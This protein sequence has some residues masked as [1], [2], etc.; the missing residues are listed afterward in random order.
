MPRTAP[1]PETVIP[2]APASH[3]A[4]IRAS[5]SR[6]GPAA[7]RLSR[8]QPGTVSVPPVT[9]AAARNGP[10][11]DRSGSTVTDPR[12]SRPGRTCQPS[13]RPAAV[14][15]LVWVTSAP[16]AWSMRTVMAMCGAEGTGGPSCRISMPSS[17]RGAASSS[18]EISCEEPDASRVTGPPRTRPCP[19]TVNGAAPRPP[20]SMLAPSWRSAARIGPMGRSLIRSSPSK[21]TCA[22]VK[23]ATAGRNRRTVP[24]LPTSTLTRE[25]AGGCPAVTRH[26]AA[27]PGSAPPSTSVTSLPIARSAAAASRVSRARSGFAI[28]AGRSDSAARTRARLVMDLDAGSRTRPRTGPAA[29]GAAQVPSWSS[30]CIGM[31]VLRSSAGAGSAWHRGSRERLAAGILAMKCQSRLNRM[32]GLPSL[33]EVLH[34]RSLRVGA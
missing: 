8:G 16:A 20:S 1:V 3:R 13:G 30:A 4:P 31:S 29:A 23:A 33:R 32:S 25:P 26:P 21:S 7:C 9:S 12:S 14:P 28:H 17:N 6:I 24:A 34:V 22:E 27:D 11:L 19:S 10:A 18:P 15:D 2:S 5:T